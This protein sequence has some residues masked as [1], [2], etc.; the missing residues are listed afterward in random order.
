MQLVIIL[1]AISGGS[2]RLFITQMWSKP[3]WNRKGAK[4]VDKD[5]LCT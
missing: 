3:E 1:K 4:I 5:M 2:I